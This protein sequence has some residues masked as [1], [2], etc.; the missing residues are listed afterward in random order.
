ML[1]LCRLYQETKKFA[2]VDYYG[3]DLPDVVLP[4]SHSARDG[5]RGDDGGRGSFDARGPPSASAPPLDDLQ[6]LP[7]SY[8]DPAVVNHPKKLHR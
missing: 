4:P 6:A 3:L 1:T 2:V 8:P 5:A 7:P